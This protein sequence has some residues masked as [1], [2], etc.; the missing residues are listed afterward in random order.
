M[1][2]KPHPETVA[3]A[4]QESFSQATVRT[5][6]AV[7]TLAE[8]NERLLGKLI[9]LSSSVA[10]ESFRTYAELQSALLDSVRTAPAPTLPSRE[11]LEELQRDPL[12]WYDKGVMGVTGATQR[13]AKLVETNAQIVARGVERF[14]ASAEQTTKEIRGVITS[15]VDRMKEIQARS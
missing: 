8:A 14:G 7:S 3:P 15:C 10:R 11:S 1:V 13:V 12:A 2:T 6:E 9:D 5:L 4:I